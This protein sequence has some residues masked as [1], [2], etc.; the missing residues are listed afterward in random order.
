MSVFRILLISIFLFITGSSV[1]A[2]GQ[3]LALDS[4]DGGH[5]LYKLS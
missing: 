2:N 1:R 5:T 4:V 3:T